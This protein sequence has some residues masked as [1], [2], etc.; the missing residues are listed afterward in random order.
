MTKFSQ[1]AEGHTTRDVAH[2]LNTGRV[3]YVISQ[4]TGLIQVPRNGMQMR[5]TRD[6]IWEI[7]PA[8]PTSSTGGLRLT[9]LRR[10]GAWEARSAA[11]IRFSCTAESFD[12]AAELTAW[13]GADEI[14]RREWAFSVPRDHV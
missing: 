4:D 14:C 11:R 2:D 8:D 10:R 5:E 3:R 1:L 6:E 12:V 9:A 13:D 7:D